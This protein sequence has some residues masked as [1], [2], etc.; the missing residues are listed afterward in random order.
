[1]R[2]QP[3]RVGPRASEAVQIEVERMLSMNVIEPS[4][5][6]W[7][8]LMVLVPKPDGSIRFR[9]DYINLTAITE[10]NFILYLEWMTGWTVSVLE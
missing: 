3:Y 6:E 5:S 2:Q 4:I 1:M 9:I 7:A 10:R 8:A